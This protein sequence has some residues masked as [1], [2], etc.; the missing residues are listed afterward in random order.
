MKDLFEPFT[1]VDMSTTRRHG[2]TGL[3]LS[4]SQRLAAILGGRIEV[5]SRPGEGSTFTLTID[6]AAPETPPARKASETAQP[7]ADDVR[8][9]CGGRVL[10]AEDS[11]DMVKL[12]QCMLAK[13]GVQLDLAADG[14]AACNQAPASRAAGTPYDLILMDIRMPVL[15]GHEA[16][17][18]LG[19]NGWTGPIVAL[20]AN[21]MRGDRDKCLQ[22]GCD[23]FLAKPVNQRAIWTV[24]QRY[25]GEIDPSRKAQ[26][27]SPDAGRPS[28][29]G[30]LFDGLIDDATANRLVQEYTDSLRLTA[31]ALVAALT[32]QDRDQLAKLAH[33]LKGVAAM[34]GFPHV[35]AKARCVQQVAEKTGDVRQVQA[36]V[37]ELIELCRAVVRESRPSSPPAAISPLDHDNPP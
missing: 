28:V 11:A 20:T 9:A 18:R 30:T 7:A 29:A 1:Q 12:I 5:A 34:Y 6:A 16:T 22:A 14:L 36:T 25:L 19:A 13:T 37:T 32:T 10:Q 24:L 27:Q 26:K 15:D 35:S 17:R 31:E 4:I 2:G 23:D 3:G 33:D 21:A 8:Q